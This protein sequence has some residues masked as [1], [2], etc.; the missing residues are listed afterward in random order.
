MFRCFHFSAS[1]A[2]K[3]LTAGSENMW[4]VS[5]SLLLL[6]PAKTLISRLLYF[7]KAVILSGFASM[8]MPFQPL[9]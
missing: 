7:L 3:V 6:T 1:A 4:Y 5:V 9:S 8:L 2:E